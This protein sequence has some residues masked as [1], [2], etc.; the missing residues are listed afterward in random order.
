MMVEALKKGDQI[1][2][3]TMFKGLRMQMDELG[4]V[5]D[6]CVHGLSALPGLLLSG[7]C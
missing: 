4:L 6:Y 2:P 1:S 7:A 3:L 5:P